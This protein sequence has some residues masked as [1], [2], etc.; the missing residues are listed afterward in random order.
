MN[1]NLWTNEQV[2][3]MF[4]CNEKGCKVPPQKAPSSTKKSNPAIPKSS[5]I[6]LPPK[7][8]EDEEE[9]LKRKRLE[10]SQFFKRPS[11]N[12]QTHNNNEYTLFFFLK[13]G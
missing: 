11:C 7:K 3:A 5:P 1:D 8:D 9:F 2:A 13:Q 12:I 10:R 6:H 4:E